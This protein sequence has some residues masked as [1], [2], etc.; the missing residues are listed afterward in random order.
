MITDYKVGDLI[1]DAYIYD[2]LNTISPFSSFPFF[3]LLEYCIFAISHKV[4]H[5]HG[6]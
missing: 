5:I 3:F 1:Y 6:G 4:S 2:G